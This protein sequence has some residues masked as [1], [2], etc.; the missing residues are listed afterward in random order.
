MTNRVFSAIKGTGGVIAD[1]YR[2]GGRT[3]R[4]A[5]LLIAIAVVPEFLQHIVEIRLGMFESL[6]QFRALSM[7]PSRWLFGYAKVAGTVIAMLTIARFWATGSVR[8]TF[9]MPPRDLGRLVLAVALTIVVSLPFDWLAKQPLPGAAIF[10]VKTISFLLQAGLTLFVAAALFGDRSLTLKTA[11][12]ERWP[13]ALVMTVALVFA[14][15]PAQ[16]LHMADHKLALGRP[17]AIVWALMI[18]DALVV[19]MLVSLVGSALWV[20]YR[21]GATWRGWA[22]VDA[23][24]PAEMPPVD[25]EKPVAAESEPGPVPGPV[26]VQKSAAERRAAARRRSR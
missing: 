2:L 11:F 1:T 4:A 13:T 14:F 16:F 9:R 5:P 23:V 12:T 3:W 25:A 20:A 15:V 7:D 10:L 26:K 8:A 17:A 24:E 19:G 22:P 18:W 6:A 21:S